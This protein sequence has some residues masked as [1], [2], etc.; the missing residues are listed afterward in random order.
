[1][2]AGLDSSKIRDAAVAQD[3]LARDRA[4]DLDLDR[5]V[6]RA[7][8]QGIIVVLDPDQGTV[9]ATLRHLLC[10][11]LFLSRYKFVFRL[12]VTHTKRSIYY[13]YLF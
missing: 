9:G 7:P 5:A 6:D 3:P 10:F 4:P 11:L 2:A 13:F 1:M 12:T 8:V